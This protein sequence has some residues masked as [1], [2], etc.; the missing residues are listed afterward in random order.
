M[1]NEYDKGGFKVPDVNI[2]CMAQ[3][4]TRNGR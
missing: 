4:I 3:K 2:V 1:S